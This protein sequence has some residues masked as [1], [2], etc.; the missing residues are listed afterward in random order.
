MLK[1]RSMLIIVG[2]LFM[3]G[4]GAMALPI[5]FEGNVDEA[6]APG[7]GPHYRFDSDDPNEGIFGSPAFDIDEIRL[8]MDA[9]WLYVGLKTVGTFDRDGV[10]DPGPPPVNPFPPETEFLFQ[11][12]DGTTNHFFIVTTTAASIAVEHGSAPHPA[13]PPTLPLLPANWSVA[14][15]EDME[16][17]IDLALMPGFD[18]TDFDFIGRLDN[19][20]QP[21]DD[22][23]LADVNIPEPATIGLLTFGLVGLISRRRLRK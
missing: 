17:K 19:S 12:N 4:S 10:V 20:N 23:V 16:I 11:T 14:I 21:P 3:C 9:S 18:F 5:T 22:I 6:Y 8:D 13:L 15:N 7:P 1:S 2:I